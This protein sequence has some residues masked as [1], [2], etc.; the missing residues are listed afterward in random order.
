MVVD[1]P[2]LPPATES[3]SS[4]A[5]A[6]ESNDSRSP[7]SNFPFFKT[8][9]AEKKTTRD[10]QPPKRRG[11][12]PDSKPALT[13]RQE[14]NRQAQR[15]HRERKEMYIKALEQEVLRLKEVFGNTSR[16]RDAIAE[17][18]RRL[19]ELLAAHGIA[20]DASSPGAGFNRMGSSY[21]GSS[22]GSMSGG[23]SYNPGSA[24]TGYTSP[25]QMGHAM[26][27]LPNNGQMHPPQQQQ[28][29]LQRPNNSVDYDQIGIDFVLTLEKPCMDHMQFL[30]VR[31]Q[32]SEA[33]VSGHALMATCPPHS[34]IVNNP[35]DKYPHQMPDLQSG[36]LMKLLDLSNR[37]PLDGEITP[38]MAWA[39]V[40][41]DER[42]GE[43]GKG[44]FERVKGDLLAKVRCYGFG[45]VLEEFEVSDALS[46]VFAAK[47]QIDDGDTRMF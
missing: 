8:Y 42:V 11:P 20:Y 14:L 47:C 28:G 30:L 24:S 26:P 10:G 43:L 25:P 27:A 5:A 46:S 17:E 39:M 23:T 21:G 18:N 9:G 7:L 41:R 13:R 45:A 4:L 22:S 1:S 37:L 3:W 15:T 19:K 34:H 38:V 44:D 6:E 2:R 16:E 31:S 12:K 40:L 33:D 32:D 35:E 36:D 29:H